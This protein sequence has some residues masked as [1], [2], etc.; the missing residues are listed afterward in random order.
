V[1]YPNE[2]GWFLLGRSCDDG[3]CSSCCRRHRGGAG[4]DGD[5]DVCDAGSELVAVPEALVVESDDERMYAASACAT[6]NVRAVSSFA[7][8][9]R[10]A[11]IVGAPVGTAVGATAA[12]NPDVGAAR[13]AAGMGSRF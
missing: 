8:V 10:S 4:V 7:A 13:R 11:T 6:G 3:V 1:G 9:V 12:S 5:R 2:V